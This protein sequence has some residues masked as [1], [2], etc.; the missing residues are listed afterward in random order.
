MDIIAS[1]F[2][3]FCQNVS[4]NLDS[5]RTCKHRP[6]KLHRSFSAKM[7]T[8]MNFKLLRPALHPRLRGL[9]RCIQC[10]KCKKNSGIQRLKHDHCHHCLVFALSS[11]EKWI[12]GSHFDPRGFCTGRG[13]WHPDAKKQFDSLFSFFCVFWWSF[14]KP[15]NTALVSFCCQTYSPTKTFKFHN[16][17]ITSSIIIMTSS[18]SQK[19]QKKNKISHVCL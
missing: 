3:N 17:F 1:V 19:K 6:P 15:K 4:P 14:G 13:D 16:I 12:Q 18:S 2:F 9:S 10:L 11:A 7:L 5:D 8:W